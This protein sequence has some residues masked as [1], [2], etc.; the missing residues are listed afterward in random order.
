M[1]GSLLFCASSAAV[2]A[3][4]QRA[5][6]R[7]TSQRGCECASASA[8]TGSSGTASASSARSRSIPPQHRVREAARPE[9][10][11]LLDEFHR[12]RDRRVCRY[13]VHVEQLVGA[14]AEQV[15]DVG[16]EACEAAGHARRD[17]RVEF[18]AAA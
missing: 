1:G 2:S 17:L 14:E 16:V 13:G 9:A 5:T 4:P 8:S 12:L 6:Q 7:A 11:P 10:V 15:H 3:A 18:G